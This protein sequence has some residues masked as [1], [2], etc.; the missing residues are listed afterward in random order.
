MQALTIARL[1]WFMRRILTQSQSEENPHRSLQDLEQTLKL[2]L[3]LLRTGILLTVILIGFERF[4]FGTS[5]ALP[6]LSLG[7]LFYLIYEV[8]LRK[9]RTDLS[10]FSNQFVEENL[11]VNAF[12]FRKED[13]E[14]LKQLAK[15]MMAFIGVIFAVSAAGETLQKYLSI[16]GELFWGVVIFG[17]TIYEIYQL[18]FFRSIGVRERTSEQLY[19]ALRR[20][21]HIGMIEYP[22]YALIYFAY[23]GVYWLSFEG[24]VLPLSILAIAIQILIFRV[25][26]NRF[27]KK[28]DAVLLQV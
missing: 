9:I 26:W 2:M 18:F 27:Q 24:M 25:F 6:G 20:I 21:Q 23:S 28:L 4:A 19:Q 14:E 8:G 22:A 12:Q 11:E 3:S 10:D 16:Q 17:R 15:P 13:L 7:I 1:S 5:H